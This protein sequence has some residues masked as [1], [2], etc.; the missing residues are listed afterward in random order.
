[1]EVAPVRSCLKQYCTHMQHKLYTQSSRNAENHTLSQH[2]S[3]NWREL[4]TIYT[5]VTLS[6]GHGVTETHLKPWITSST[7]IFKGRRSTPLVNGSEYIFWAD[8][9]SGSLSDVATAAWLFQR[10][11]I[12]KGFALIELNVRLYLAIPNICLKRLMA[13]SQRG[14]KEPRHN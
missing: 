3:P 5:C 2:F 12:F 8:F 7:L 1:M 11:L 13:L 10:L 14:S 6:S 9:H 4:F